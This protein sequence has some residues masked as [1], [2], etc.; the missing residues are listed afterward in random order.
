MLKKIAIITIT[1][2]ALTMN[3]NAA[4]DEDLIL[5]K[6]SPEQKGVVDSQNAAFHTISCKQY[7]LPN[8]SN[9]P[10]I[11]TKGLEQMKFRQI[12]FRYVNYTKI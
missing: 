3:V 11:Q 10:A 2:L 1:T 6:N 12:K 9:A 5:K 7:A 4:S 8:Q